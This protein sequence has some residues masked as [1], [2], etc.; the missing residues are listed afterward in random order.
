MSERLL[1]D[2][3]HEMIGLTN[4]QRLHKHLGSLHRARLTWIV[5]GHL[6]RIVGAF[7]LLTR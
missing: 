6:E 2:E 1:P 5:V 7:G 3:Q 4:R